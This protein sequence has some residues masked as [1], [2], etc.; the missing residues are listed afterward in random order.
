MLVLKVLVLELH[1]VDGFPAGAIASGKVPSLDH[2]LLDYAVEDGAFVPERL[3]RFALALLTGAEGAE[4]FCCLGHHIVVK[5][6]GNST[7]ELLAN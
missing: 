6:K 3:S 5:F 4:V 7:L 2:E 1:A